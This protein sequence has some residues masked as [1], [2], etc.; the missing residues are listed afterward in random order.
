MTL[1]E[2]PRKPDSG[3]RGGILAAQ[4]TLLFVLLSIWQGVVAG[5]LVAEI[6]VSEPSAILIA[7]WRNL[8]GF[9]LIKALL[10]TVYETLAGFI[11]ASAV[12][13]LVGILLYQAPRVNLVVRPFLTG[14]NNI[15]RL[16]LAPLFVLWF[17]LETASRVAL[18]LSVVFFIVMLNTYAGLQSANPDHLLL[19]RTLGA[20]RRVLF[21]K[22]ILPSAAP[23]VF[24]GL[25]LGLTYSF[26]TAVVGEMLS[27]ATGMGAQLQIE[28][29]TYRTADFFASLFLL[30][31]VAT[32]LSAVMRMV[33]RHLLRW[34]QFEL[35]GLR[36]SEF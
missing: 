13:M 26:L 14:L 10:V 23:T 28:L 33:E 12:G 11:F 22:F 30:A 1:P 5:G 19:A 21:T 4:I 18:I 3:R 20:N 27:G 7:L 17:G 25:Q 15:P 35:S 34:R 6:F 2:G 36:Q 24:A 29:G 8:M 32:A 31:L 16:A 9:D